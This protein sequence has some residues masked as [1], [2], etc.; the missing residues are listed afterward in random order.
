M[1]LYHGSASKLSDMTVRSGDLFNGMFFSSRRD[2]ALSHGENLYIV[3]I[4][5]DEI[6]DA[7]HFPYDD[8][9]YRV[10]A[11]R[12]GDENAETMADLI[13]GNDSVW[14]DDDL[15]EKAESILEMVN[16]I[17][18]YDPADVDFAIQREAS[19]IAE[20]LGFKAVAVEDEHGT[21]Y[22]VCPGAKMKLAE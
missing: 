18:Y 4:P 17:G 5:E 7:R 21:S 6:V 11:E 16:G 20:A 15:L 13:A 12:Y 8:D 3:D 2:A 10:M 14:N 9:A 1:N 19:I 22:I